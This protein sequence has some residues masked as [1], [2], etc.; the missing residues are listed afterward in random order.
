LDEHAGKPGKAHNREMLSLLGKILHSPADKTSNTRTGSPDEKAIQRQSP[1]SDATPVPSSPVAM[2]CKSKPST[3]SPPS[4]NEYLTPLPRL[5]RRARRD[6]EA[7]YGN[8]RLADFEVL[9]SQRE[10]HNMKQHALRELLGRKLRRSKQLTKVGSKRVNIR[11]SK[12]RTSRSNVSTI[13]GSDAPIAVKNSSTDGGH[14][15]LTRS[16][17]MNLLPPGCQIADVEVLV[18]NASFSNPCRRARQRQASAARKNA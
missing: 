17:A 5:T 10:F 16:R 18:R 13:S 9:I 7:V 11:K 12:K 3:I 2:I 14:R 15:H 8:V 4:V 6:D 1:L